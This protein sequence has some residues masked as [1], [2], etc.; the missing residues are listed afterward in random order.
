MLPDAQRWA[1]VRAQVGVVGVAGATT[2]EQTTTFGLAASW[3][4]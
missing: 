1:G 2:S 3:L 4:R